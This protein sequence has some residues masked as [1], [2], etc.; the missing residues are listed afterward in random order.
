MVKYKIKKVIIFST[1]VLLLGMVMIP[2]TTGNLDIENKI[3]DDKPSLTNIDDGLVGYWSFDEGSGTIVQ[4]DSG[5]SNDGTIVGANWISGISGSAL[6]ITNKEYVGDI[7]SYFDDPISTA[8]TV[9]AWVKWYGSTG[10][11]S[12]IFDGRAEIPSGFAFYIGPDRILR[13]HLHKDDTI[14]S[15]SIIPSDGTWIHVA[16]VFDHSNDILRLYIN[17]NQD[18]TLTTTEVYDDSYYNPVIGN[19]LWAP[20]DGKWRPFNGIIDEVRIYNRALSANEIQKLFSNPSGLKSTLFFGKIDNLNTG[21]GNFITFNAVKVRS[22][23]FSPFKYIQ[24]TSGEKI[25]ISEI[26]SGLLNPKFIFGF[27]KANI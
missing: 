3:A 23:S 4:D 13:F 24:Y 15:I 17:G 21:I 22:I 12:I 18:N 11:D 19:N 14:Q 10:W 1:L 2:S 16:A 25:R 8:L 27:F 7:P 26:Y 6:E 5:N 20:Y 9:T